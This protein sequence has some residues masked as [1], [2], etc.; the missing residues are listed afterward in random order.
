MFFEAIRS[1]RLLM[2]TVPMRL[3]QRWY[4]G[5]DLG[6]ELPDHSSLSKIMEDAHAS[7]STA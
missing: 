7:F 5:Y 6:E 4:L 2:K 3:D 1:E